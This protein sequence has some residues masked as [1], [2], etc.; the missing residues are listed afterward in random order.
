MWLNTVK[1]T[2]QSN[3]LELTRKT[4]FFRNRRVAKHPENVAIT[5]LGCKIDCQISAHFF[6]SI[7]APCQYW[8]ILRDFWINQFLRFFLRLLWQGRPVRRA[9]ARGDAAER[10]VTR[11][12]GDRTRPASPTRTLIKPISSSCL[13][14]AADGKWITGAADIWTLLKTRL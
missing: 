11:H 10:K 14:F 7:F 6:R 1:L 13:L 3:T 8:F 9:G 5:K 12:C 2:G 4:W